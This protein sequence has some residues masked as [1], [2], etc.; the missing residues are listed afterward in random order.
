MMKAKKQSN[1]EFI[2]FKV[3]GDW[4]V[5][6]WN[7]LLDCVSK[8]YNVFLALKIVNEYE[9]NI[10]DTFKSTLNNLTVS[11]VLINFQDYVDEGAKLRIHKIKIASLGGFSFTGSGE[12]IK[13]IK[14]VIVEFYLLTSK[15]TRSRLENEKIE[16]ENAKEK[17]E[18][19]STQVG[20]IKKLM[21]ILDKHPLMKMVAQK[22]KHNI[23]KP[24]IE[25]LTKIARYQSQ[26]I[27]LN[28]V[29]N[30]DYSPE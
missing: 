12:I 23:I 26:G 17:Q 21:D 28:V 25:S 1:S 2:G 3:S 6:E 22:E 20:N 19:L 30:I 16:L 8:I 29:D 13:E 7:T 11:E 27:L 9:T 4:T 18:I 15:K 24:L 5:D 14:N 10:P